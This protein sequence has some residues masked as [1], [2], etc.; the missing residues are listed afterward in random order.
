MV[1]ALRRGRLRLE[2]WCL[3]KEAAFRWVGVEF[4][5]RLATARRGRWP[6]DAARGRGRPLPSGSAPGADVAVRNGGGIPPS[7]A[8]ALVWRDIRKVCVGLQLG[9]RAECVQRISVQ[10][11]D[12]QSGMGPVLAGTYVTEWSAVEQASKDAVMLCFDAWRLF[13]FAAASAGL[14]TFT[15]D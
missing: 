12:V 5:V 13:C 3:D 4:A 11:K 6:V 8:T 2:A 9:G 10:P 14:V 1:V 7:D 15:A